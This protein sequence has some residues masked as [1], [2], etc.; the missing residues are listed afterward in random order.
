[1]STYQND[2]VEKEINEKLISKADQLIDK[3]LS[4]PRMKL[5]N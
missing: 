2:S 5:S 4:S 1:M 3:N